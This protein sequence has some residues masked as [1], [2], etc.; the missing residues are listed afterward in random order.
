MRRRKGGGRGGEADR[1]IP[2]VECVDSVNN[3]TGNCSVAFISK[4]TAE[5]F[6]HRLKHESD[7]VQHDIQ[8]HRK[9]LLN[10]F[11]LNNHT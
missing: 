9:V 7:R 4:V 1:R 6:I 10:I 11:H 3:S 5:E 8:Y 2:S